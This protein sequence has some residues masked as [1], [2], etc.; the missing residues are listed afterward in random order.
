MVIPPVKVFISEDS[1]VVRERL[2]SFLLATVT[3]IEIA[4]TAANSNDTLRTI[5]ALRPDVAI[6]DLWMGDRNNIESLEEIRKQEPELFIIVLTNDAVQQVREKCLAL[7]AD[8]IFD[9][10][11]EFEKARNAVRDFV[12]KRARTSAKPAALLA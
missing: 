10:S 1:F 7:G 12:E 5:Q 9:K 6:L 8:C 11:N 3:G 4:G 2:L